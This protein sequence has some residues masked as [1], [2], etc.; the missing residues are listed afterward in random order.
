MSVALKNYFNNPSYYNN[1]TTNFDVQLL[2]SLLQV[3]L[4]GASTL[5]TDTAVLTTP[6][7]IVKFDTRR[8]PSGDITYILELKGACGNTGFISGFVTCSHMIVYSPVYSTNTQ[9]TTTTSSL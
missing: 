2:D 3:K 5:S 7:R 8:S 4:T 1:Y 9:T 6:V